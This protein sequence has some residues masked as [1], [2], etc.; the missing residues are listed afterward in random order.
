MKE[1]E[2]EEDEGVEGFKSKTNILA[3]EK[4]QVNYQHTHTHSYHVQV[5]VG[6][7][8][9]IHIF[10]GCAAVKHCCKDQMNAILHSFSQKS[11]VV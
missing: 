6:S 9:F 3:E 11:D 2:K 5:Y 8:P 4:W 7:Q 10:N 1:E